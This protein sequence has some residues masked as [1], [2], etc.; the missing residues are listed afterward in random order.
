MTTPYGAETEPAC[1]HRA[2]AE[3]IRNK[4][5]PLISELR[6]EPCEG[7]VVVHGRTASFYGKQVALHEVARL[8]RQTI[9]RNKISVA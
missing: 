4:N 6:I 9:V 5:R 7:G 2:V 8:C 3:G 1:N